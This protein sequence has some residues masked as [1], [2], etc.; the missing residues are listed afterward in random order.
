LPEDV[1]EEKRREELAINAIQD[2][3]GF[4]WDLH[5]ETFKGITMKHFVDEI[6]N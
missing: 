1:R 3:N 6:C 2:F 5:E 4:P